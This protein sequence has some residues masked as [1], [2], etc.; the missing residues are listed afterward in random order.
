MRVVFLAVVAAIGSVAGLHAEERTWTDRQG[1]TLQ[2]EFVTAAGDTVYLRI[3]G[4]LVPLKLERLSDADQALIAEARKKPKS[5][6]I[7]IENRLW[8]SADGPIAGKF[9]RVDGGAVLLSLGAKEYRLSYRDLVE[10]DREYVRKLLESRGEAQLLT[11]ADNGDPPS[12]EPGSSAPALPDAVSESLTGAAEESGVTNEPAPEEPNEQATP[13]PIEPAPA[14]SAAPPPPPAA[15]YTPSHDAPPIS[16]PA[17]PRHEQELDFMRNQ[18]LKAYYF[19]GGI[20]GILLF[21]G[22]IVYAMQ[23]F[24]S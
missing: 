6:R 13:A 14:P 23:Q 20:L 10:A 21:L 11:E 8:Q 2:G 7:K 15:S 12:K 3:N 22:P 16:G 19:L 24:Y 1:R 9:V 18:N 5:A 4:K 17:I